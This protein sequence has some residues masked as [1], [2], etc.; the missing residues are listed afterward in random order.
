MKV[1]DLILFYD[2]IEDE[3]GLIVERCPDPN[4][5]A[6]V[7]IQFVGERNSE[8]P[9]HYYDFELRGWKKSGSIRIYHAR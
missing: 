8:G 6:A 1:G 5:H 4:D 7:L 9:L 3:V 2:E